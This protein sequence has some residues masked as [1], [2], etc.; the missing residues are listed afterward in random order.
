MESFCPISLQHWALTLSAYS[1][2]IAFKPESR[3]ENADA[4]SQLPVPIPD[5]STKPP[6]LPD[7]IFLFQAIGTCP[8]TAKQIL[9]WTDRDPLLSQVSDYITKGLQLPQTEEMQPYKTTKGF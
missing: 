2:N 6:L 7:H 1:Y 5:D 8:I 3:Y 9:L 4:F